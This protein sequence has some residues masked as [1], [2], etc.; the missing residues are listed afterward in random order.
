M[1]AESQRALMLSCSVSVR[2]AAEMTLPSRAAHV[3]QTRSSRASNTGSTGTVNC[4]VQPSGRRA[5]QRWRVPAWVCQCLKR[6]FPLFKQ[7]GPKKIT[8]GESSLLQWQMGQS[9]PE[10]SESCAG[11]KC[12]V[13]AQALFG[14]LNHTFAEVC[15]FGIFYFLLV[16]LILSPK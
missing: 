14:L 16:Q 10:G 1:T 8:G 4:S 5:W 3:G 7:L 9:Q 12:W 15:H 6:P 11:S 2:P 13:R